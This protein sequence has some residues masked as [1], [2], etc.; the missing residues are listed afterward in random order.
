[1][2]GG[3]L[4]AA[5]L[6]A[7][8]FLAGAAAGVRAQVPHLD[9]LPWPSPADSL[10]RLSLVVEADRF[11]DKA[12]D[13]SVNRIMLTATIPAG[14]RAAWF[15]RMPYLTFDSAGFSAAERWP[16]TVGEDQEPGWP[17]GS[18]LDGFGQI[19]IGAVGRARLPL[20]GPSRYGLAMGLPTGQNTLYPW[21]STS[22]PLRV[23]VQRLVVPGRVWS[24][25]LGGGFL[26]HMDASGD[27]LHEDAF[28]DGWQAD[29]ELAAALPSGR[30]WRLGACWQ[31]RDGRTSLLA[32]GEVQFPWSV[33]GALG[34]RVARELADAA[35]R[36]AQWYFTAIW[37]FDAV[38]APVAP[39]E[40]SP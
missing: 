21:S 34:L 9:A 20:V 38:G 27:D 13:W 40:P 12:S 19:E 37:R 6:C 2:R 3:R 29:A 16:A 10:A 36:P 23:Q 25:W 32:S 22:L 5:A 4:A 11:L 30:L 17:Y 14:Q 8:C 39:D 1:V 35:D 28:P 7:A 33:G 15:L 26:A 18:R 24:F 31:D